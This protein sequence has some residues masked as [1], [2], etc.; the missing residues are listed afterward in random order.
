[1]VYN[2][3]SS[4]NAY[5]VS[6]FPCGILPHWAQAQ[7]NAKARLYVCRGSV[8]SVGT[9]ASQAS[10]MLASTYAAPSNP[11]DHSYHAID[12]CKPAEEYSMTDVT[13]GQGEVAEPKTIVNVPITK[14]KGT[15]AVTIEDIPADV[16]SE[17]ILQGLKVIANRGA[18]KI[19]KET[20]PKAEELQS[21]AMSK[22]DEQVQAMYDG[23][24][25]ITGGKSASKVS[26]AIM[27]EARRLAKNM[28]KDAMK[29][30]KIKISHVEAS[31]I[32]K[33]ANALI[34]DDP[35]IVEM[36]KTNLEARQAVPVKIN[37]AAIPVSDKLVAKANERKAK[38]Q[39]SAKQAGKTAKHKAK[40]KSGEAQA[41]AH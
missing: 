19:T 30:A 33:A 4:S 8:G 31:E 16:W 9:Y 41:T 24:T 21:A 27:T 2:E 38:D 28:V 34:A 40:P 36:A 1:M 5:T 37:V 20:Y 18:S 26:G 22:A 29:A 32:T 35:T 13:Q 6:T 15:I 3:A 23:K 7:P 12:L 25:K 14:G 11:N 10:A 39:L 17:V